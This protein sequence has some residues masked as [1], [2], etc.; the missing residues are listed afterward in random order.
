MAQRVIFKPDK[1]V[2]ELW[3]QSTMVIPNDTEIKRQ[4]VIMRQPWGL[5]KKNLLAN[6][7]KT[8]PEYLTG[9]N[10]GRLDKQNFQPFHRDGN[11]E[12]YMRGYHDGYTGS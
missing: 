8:T 9:L 5:H 7:T 10:Q 1:E 2:L 4:A 11:G 3:S 6:V 12:R